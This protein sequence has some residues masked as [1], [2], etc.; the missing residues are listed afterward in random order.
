MNGKTAMKLLLATFLLLLA[1]FIPVTREL[2]AADQGNSALPHRMDHPPNDP[3]TPQESVER[4]TAPPGFHV[5]LVA[6][7]PEVVN[8]IAMTFDERG[9]IW[10][11]ESVEY[12]RK[13]AGSGRDKVILI[14]GVDD[15]GHAKKVSTFAEGFNIPTGIAVG[16]GGA[17]VLNSPDLLFLREKDGKEV[18]REV[19][20]TG[21]GRVDFH[22]LPSSLTWG[23]DGWLYGL[24]GVFNPSEIV[25]KH[26]KTHRFT[27]AMWRF[28]PC[29]REF[30]VFAEGT[31]N[32]WG[33]AWDS[34]GSAIIEACHWANDHLF[35]FVETGYY[36]RQAGA[37]PAFTMK[38]GS[39]T[40]HGHQKTAYCG[41]VNLDTDAFPPEYRERICVGNVHAGCINVDRLA[42]DGAT[43]HGTGEPDLLTAHDDW[44]MPVSLKLGP[45]GFLYVLDWY[46]RYHCSQD[47]I[48]DPDGVDRLRG[49]LYRLRYGDSPRAVPLDLAAESDQQLVARLSSN[50]LYFRET[51]QRVLTERLAEI[52]GR[53]NASGA[54]PAN[55]SSNDLRA[56]LEKLV[57]NDAAPRKARLHALW[58][59]IGGDALLPP[60]HNKLLA[61]SDPTFRAWAVRAA[62]NQ[63]KVAPELREAIVALAHDPSPDV[64][65]QVA[66]AS[67]KIDGCDALAVLV[68]V[69]GACGHDKLMPAVV[70]ANLHPLLETDGARLVTLLKSH[71]RSAGKPRGGAVA[72]TA[73]IAPAVS[74]LIPRMIERLLGA[75]QPNVEAVAA[76]LQL[77]IENDTARGPDCV[78]AISARLGGLSEPVLAELKRQFRPIVD[79]I[80]ADRRTTPLRLST[81]LLAAR[82]QLASFDAA[83]VRRMFVSRAETDDTR[84]QALE[85]MIAF[86]DPSLSTAL[87][88]A[89]AS[90]SPA[91]T[92]RVFTALSRVE[93]PQLGDVLLTQYLKLAPE[94]QP[95]AVDLIMQREPWAKKLLNAVLAGKL[96]KSILDANQLRKIMDSND[97][98][99]IWAVEK[100]FGKIRE[101]RNPE[102]EKVVAEMSDYLRKN[103][104]DPVAG[105][106]VF[107]TLCAQ[108]HMIYGEGRRVGPDLTSSGRGTFDQVVVSVFDPSLVIGPGY[109]TV[110]VVTEDGRNL[111][112]LI[113]E[114][115]PQQVVLRMAG[116]GEVA[117]PR[118]NVQYTRVSKLSLMPE[119]IENVFTRQQLS[120]L[121]AF[122][123]LDKPPS[124]PT[125]KPIRGAPAIHV[126]RP[127]EAP[128]KKSGSM[129]NN[130]AVP[131]KVSAGTRIKIDRRDASLIV[132]ARLPGKQ[133]WNE[134]ATF[135][136]DPKLRP[137][138]HPL[139][140]AIGSA[141]LTED[142]PADHVWQHGIFTGFHQ[143]NG[144]NYWKENEGQQHFVKLLD[145]KESSQSVSWRALVNLIDP[146]GTVVLEEEDAI[147]IH[148]PESPDAYLID[149]ELLLRAKGED[150]KFGKYFVGG[151]SARMP[152]D[153]V[154]P[155]Q[156]HLNS[157]GDRNRQCEQQRAEWC[158][159][160]RPFGEDIYGI[161]IFDHPSNSPHPPGWRADEQ[162]LVN[163]NVSA[164]SAWSIP[165]G[166]EQVFRYQLLVYR[167]TATRE[168]LQAR[169]QNFATGRSSASDLAPIQ[170]P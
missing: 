16:Y 17:W 140:D 119:G 48:R 84:L 78:A 72:N 165:A 68:A 152:W 80:L 65:L 136:M 58:T 61:H 66:I 89:L 36:E 93:D 12:P 141:T 13:S 73:A 137:Y 96:P 1:V 26:G 149:F 76:L 159:V 8:P 81:L 21:F 121:F 105:Q 95:L 57:L 45:D 139:R 150:V 71:A 11:T 112:G 86:R 127:N 155:R 30:Q 67:R 42:R 99:A 64:Q 62:G 25:D 49:R 162:G 63:G 74:T 69:L 53:A 113:L 157:N 169:Y 87:P 54:A 10:I 126:G 104:G 6:S 124:D 5:D 116:G 143:V 2:F 88:E 32:P 91:L 47:A 101:E 148:A 164:L 123:S 132:R 46:D 77:V 111:T 3:L 108:C 39:I 59:L 146:K 128:A 153:K 129:S 160:E 147:T 144:F 75:R 70:W 118:N 79:N 163:P 15:H 4:M 52:G 170:V 114:D 120:D 85:A 106:K 97:R 133:D 31:S 18:S 154:N 14:D 151:L 161:A 33:I 117:V 130:P 92:A 166:K 135:V 98:E 83:E 23:P 107:K 56:A 35:H 125:A 102:R 94:L 22:E 50:N 38:I 55:A 41:I 34:E 44:A 100:A 24:N 134:I 158:N 43:Y 90:M 168:Q 110:T 145:V 27:C 40:D 51:T 37:Y 103:L 167:N 142:K 29:T 109:Q 7:E 60:L 138:L 20:L 28:H 131:A 122:L 19:V 9:R 156:T 82:L 115:S